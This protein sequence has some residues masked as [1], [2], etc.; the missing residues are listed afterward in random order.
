MRVTGPFV[1]HIPSRRELSRCK[2]TFLGRLKPDKHHAKAG[3]INNALYNE[4][5]VGHYVATF[6]NDMEPHP[7]FLQACMTYFFP[8]TI[9]EDAQANWYWK[10][11]DWGDFK[12]PR[13]LNAVAFV[14]TPQYFKTDRDP[15]TGRFN[16]E[17]KGM[18]GGDPAGHGNKTF[19]DAHQHGRDG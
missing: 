12:Q 19:F 15:V 1:F 7:L 16:R 9:P 5:L 13:P 14:Q 10:M 4:G 17:V 18:E 8:P 3:N 11:E 6:D 2:V